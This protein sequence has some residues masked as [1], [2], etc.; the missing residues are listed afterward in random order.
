[1]PQAKSQDRLFPHQRPHPRRA[2]NQGPRD[3][4]GAVERKHSVRDLNA[5]ETSSAVAVAGTTVTL[6]PFCRSSAQNI[7]F[8]CPLV[9]GND[10]M[11]VY[12]QSQGLRASARVRHLVTDHGLAQVDRGSGPI[13]TR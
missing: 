10:S 6:K 5:E 7:F 12:R 9:V 11:S 4:R 3:R 8:G 1:M 2:R 13:D